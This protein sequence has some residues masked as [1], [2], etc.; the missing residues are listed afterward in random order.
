MKERHEVA[1]DNFLRGLNCSQSVLLAFQDLTKLD[2]GAL[3][4]IARGFGA[5][6]GRKGEVCGAVSGGIT[7]IGLAI[8]TLDLDEA[9]KR[10]TTYSTVNKLLADF[11]QNFS[12]LNCRELLGGC[13]LTTSEGQALFKKLDMRTMVCKKCVA[14][15]TKITLQQIGS[16][17]P[18]TLLSIDP[19]NL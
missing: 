3:L 5:G 11:S 6:M 19:S 2:E 17:L 15:S 14:E 10:E 7:A 12:T 9:A 13:D 4:S 18:L 16:V 1:T 8:G